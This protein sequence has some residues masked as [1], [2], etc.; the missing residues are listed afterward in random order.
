MRRQHAS[1]SGPGPRG[2]GG[3]V[4]CDPPPRRAPRFGF[5]KVYCI[6]SVPLTLVTRHCTI[7]ALHMALR[8]P[9]G[10]GTCARPPTAA[11]LAPPHSKHSIES[12]TPSS[13]LR[14]SCL[15]R[16]HAAPFLLVPYP[17]CAGPACAV[18]SQ[19]TP[20]VMSSS[21]RSCPSP[22]R[23]CVR[24]GAHRPPALA[25]TNNSPSFLPMAV[26]Q[27]R[28]V[29]IIAARPRR[30]RPPSPPRVPPPGLG[31]E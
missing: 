23:A 15:C 21:S 7:R 13:V 9:D 12:S 8:L 22:T 27:R 28:S 14:R 29:S 25:V 18:K 19:T 11:T 5:A 26:A 1:G 16:I 20:M 30:H 31:C 4:A 2:G 6:S 17:C 3:A 10:L 24:S